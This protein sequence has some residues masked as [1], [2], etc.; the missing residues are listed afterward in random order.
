M[1]CPECG[2]ALPKVY[3]FGDVLECP[4]C[5]R[6]IAVDVGED[7]EPAGDEWEV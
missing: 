6:L 4:N 1:N 2:E 7:G 3:D 5:G